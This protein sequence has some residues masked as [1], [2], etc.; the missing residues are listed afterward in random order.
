MYWLEVGVVCDGEAAEAVAEVLRPLAYNDG[1]V[2]EQRGDENAAEADA[3][4]PEVTVKIYVP[5]EQDSASLRRRI[6]EILYYLGRLYPIPE[7]TFR[8]LED[9]D[10]AEAWK[11]HYRP[12]RV[13]QRLWIRPSWMTLEEPRAAEQVVLTLDPGMA[14][15][16][17]LHPTT[18]MCLR[19]LEELVE[20]GSSVLD[21][22]AGSGIL[23]IAAA[24]LGAAEVLAVD[25]DE[26]AVVAAATNVAE[27]GVTGSV[28]VR[29]GSLAA[30]PRRDWDLVVVNILATV[31]IAM[32]GEDDL[33]DYVAGEGRLLLS[34]IIEEQLPALQSALADAGGA[35]V[36]QWAV[37]D[38][39]TVVA[40]HKSPR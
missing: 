22:G 31:I 33:L 6:Q 18:Q 39:V 29:G 11:A 27:N 34:G 28:A 40:R 17:G 26:L 12:F 32:L 1:V 30:V 21:V 23:S 19:A 10:W 37:R 24:K 3:L 36:E 7:P 4:E 8:K 14:F 2:L 13:G 25:T 16:T 38:W 9:K 5:G 35:I 15:G 20:A